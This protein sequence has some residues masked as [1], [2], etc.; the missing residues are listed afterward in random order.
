MNLKLKPIERRLFL[1]LLDRAQVRNTSWGFLKKCRG[2]VW[3]KFYTKLI[4]IIWIFTLRLIPSL[5]ILA[6]LSHVFTIYAKELNINRPS[7]PQNMRVFLF[8]GSN[9]IFIYSLIITS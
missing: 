1:L 9:P 6:T 7:I 3:R 5:R 8:D 4:L 2:A